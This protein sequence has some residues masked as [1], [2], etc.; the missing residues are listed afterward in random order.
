M[1]QLWRAW[2][3]H[4][5]RCVPVLLLCTTPAVAAL[6]PQYERLRQLQAI[7]GDAQIAESLSRAG[8]IDRI[9]WIEGLTFRVGAGACEMAVT[10]DVPPRSQGSTPPMSGAPIPYRVVPGKVACK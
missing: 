6:A 10:L 1:Q 4:L 7:L 3:R 2:S 5:L 8:P 9:Q